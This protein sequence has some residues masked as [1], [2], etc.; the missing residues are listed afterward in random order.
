[1]EEEK[2]LPIGT[3]IL[4]KNEIVLYMI[5]GYINKTKDGNIKD[6]IC[7]PFP[8]GFM[9]DK[10]VSYFNHDDIEKVVFKGYKDEKYKELNKILNENYNKKDV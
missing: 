5:A 9:S 1:M 7:I 3:I 8:Y 4:K 10:I 2:Y 6:Y